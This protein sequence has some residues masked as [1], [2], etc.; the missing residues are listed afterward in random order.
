MNIF[1]NIFESWKSSGVWVI[2]SQQ[3][4]APMNVDNVGNVS[5]VLVLFMGFNYLNYY[6]INLTWEKIIANSLASNSTL[7]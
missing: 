4:M 3:T 2:R 6:L 1:C 7:F 5:N